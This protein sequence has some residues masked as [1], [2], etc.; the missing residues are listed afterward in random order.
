[1]PLLT[2]NNLHGDTQRVCNE[3]R[4]RA[5]LPGRVVHLKE[6]IVKVEQQM[7]A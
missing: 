7:R 4:Q 3:F 1:V 2:I 5:V 6:M